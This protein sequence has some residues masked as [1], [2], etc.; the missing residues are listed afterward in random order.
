SKIVAEESRWSFCLPHAVS[1]G[2][3]TKQSAV[4]KAL[5]RK[6]YYQAIDEFEA[7]HGIAWDDIGI[8]IKGVSL[9][10]G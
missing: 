5:H 8:K 2:K 7:R 9:H 6:D 3:F 10:Q 1:F 4:L